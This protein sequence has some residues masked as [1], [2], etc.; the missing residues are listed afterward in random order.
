MVSVVIVRQS[1]LNTEHSYI[2]RG[3]SKHFPEYTSSL[4]II[5]S[6]TPKQCQ[7]KAWGS[8]VTQWLMGQTYNDTT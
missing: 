3:G 8:V 7:Y 2:E 1:K 4:P 5:A 6:T